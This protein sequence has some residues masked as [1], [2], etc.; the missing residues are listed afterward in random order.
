M[1][2]EV[3]AHIEGPEV[4]DQVEQLRAA[5]RDRRRGD[6]HA[7]DLATL[8]AGLSAL[9]DDRAATVGRAFTLFFLLINTAEQVHRV[10]RRRGYDSEEPQSGSSRWAL[11]QLHREGVSAHDAAEALAALRVSPV[12]TAHPTESTRR[13]VLKLLSRLANAL[14]ARD[15]ATAAKRVAELDAEIR[16]EIELLWLTSQVRTD[17]LSVLDEVSSVLWYLEDRLI[18]AGAA[19]MEELDQAFNAVYGEPLPPVTPVAP[20]TWVG[21]DRDGN[22]FVTPEVTYRAANLAADRILDIYDN[23]LLDAIVRASLSSRQPIPDALAESLE[24][25]RAALPDVAARHAVRDAQ[26]P[27]RQKL[28]FIRARVLARREGAA[29]AYTSPQ[30]LLDDLQLVAEAATHAGASGWVRRVIVPLQHRVR[31]H[32][33]H[34]LKMDVRED[35]SAHTRALDDIADHIGIPSLD[36]A[37]LTT[38]LLGRRP[39]L[40][41]DTRVEES[42]RRTVDVFHTVRRLQRELGPETVSTYIISMAR[43]EADVLRV[44]LLAREAGLVDLAADAPQSSLDIVPLF[45][46]RDDLVN[47]PES[48][49]QMFTNPAYQRQL[50]ARNNRQEVMLGYSDSAK[51]AGVLPAAWALYTAQEA[52]AEVCREHGVALTLFHGRGGT[53]GRGGGSPVLRALTALPPHT[54][55]AQIRITEQG[56]VISQKFSIPSLAVR[57]LEVMTMGTLLASRHDWR[58]GLV[59]GEEAAF[60][61]VMERLAELALPV[62]RTAVHDEQALFDVFLNATPVRELAHVHYGSRPAYRDRGTGTMAGIRAIP[63][64]FGW[65]QIRLMLPGWFGVGTALATVAAE[66]NGLAQL[67]R[68]ASAWPFFDDL[69]AKIEM[70]C[71]KADLEIAERYVSTRVGN[72]PIWNELVAE[73]KRTVDTVLAIRQADTLLS[74]NAMLRRSIALRNPYVDALSLLQ[75]HLLD[76]R[77]GLPEEHPERLGLNQALGTITNGIAQGMR[78]TG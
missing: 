64:V 66:P 50:A 41:P 76:R 34:G 62:F 15:T 9:P 22:P 26:E 36:V 12:L 70:V 44:L 59:E 57:S 24:A 8:Q 7:K 13:S 32:G 18:D 1:L 54:V 71:A 40:G 4:L 43:S 33:F 51:D 5:C 30:A 63:W 39:L 45:E 27:I 69:L 37:G 19:L 61:G 72:T 53:V 23:A 78:N 56:E 52:L 67:Q 55:D 16:S 28:K 60:R 46:T 14:I 17:R 65:T 31:A 10:R 47:G 11:E 2:G 75:L 77:D 58:E 29:T 20:G 6:A 21:G 35:S 73:Y 68:M 49:R 48:L 38:E 25:D 42:T 3:I 74:R